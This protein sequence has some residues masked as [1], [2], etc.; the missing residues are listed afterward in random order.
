MNDRLNNGFLDICHECV[1]QIR[2]QLSSQSTS[3]VRD[4]MYPHQQTV[5]RESLFKLRDAANVAEFT[6]VTLK[7]K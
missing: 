7:E 6:F 5:K 2:S 3:H 1:T 4:V